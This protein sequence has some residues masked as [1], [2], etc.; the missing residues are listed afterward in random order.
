MP[1]TQRRKLD[2][3]SFWPP[4]AQAAPFMSLNSI[5]NSRLSAHDQHWTESPCPSRQIMANRA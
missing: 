3:P 5:T 1:S 4:P 2:R